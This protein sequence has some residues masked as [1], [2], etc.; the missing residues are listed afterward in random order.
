MG[1]LVSAPNHLNMW[2]ADTAYELPIIR[3]TNSDD[4]GCGVGSTVTV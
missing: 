3:N 1:E 4:Y 2:T